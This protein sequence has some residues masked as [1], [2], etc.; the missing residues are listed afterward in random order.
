MLLVFRTQHTLTAPLQGF[1]V[2]A[3]GVVG[4]SGLTAAKDTLPHQ[5]IA[6]RSQCKE[7]DQFDQAKQ[8]N[9]Q[10]QT[11]NAASIGNELSDAE[12]FGTTAS[13][14]GGTFEEHR[15]PDVSGVFA[16]NVQSGARKMLIRFVLVGSLCWAGRK[17]VCSYSNK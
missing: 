2:V 7:V 8:R 17:L 4:F 13:D 5:V 12:Q 15:Q 14:E 6:E 11:E 10:I 3:S 1:L 16:N 9:A